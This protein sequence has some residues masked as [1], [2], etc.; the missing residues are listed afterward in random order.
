MEISI[1]LCEDQGAEPGQSMK[2]YLFRHG[3]TKYNLEHRYQGKT[4]L[5]LLET[6]FDRI[7]PIAESSQKSSQKSSPNSSP[8]SSQKN[9]QKSSPQSS[10]KCSQK[11][12]F[13][14]RVYVSPALRARQTAELLFPG[15]KQIVVP[16]FAEMDFGIFEG[17]SAR[18]MENDPQYREWV[19]SMCEGPVPQGESKKDYTARVTER[20]LSLVREELD[21]GSSELCIVAHGGTQMAVMERF[22]EEKRSYW[23]WQGVP[24]DGIE[25][26]IIRKEI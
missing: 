22:C 18:E 9:S 10:Q 5:P 19:G 26:W 17:R 6:E 8:K 16:E 12:G 13:P 7:R 4:D 23:T 2:L 15:V 24:G 3:Y 11:E 14:G 1:S 20:F 25:A 21:H